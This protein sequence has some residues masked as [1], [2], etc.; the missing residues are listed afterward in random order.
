MAN[1][2]QIRDM[3]FYQRGNRW[4]DSR[5]VNEEKTVEPAKVV[6]FGSAKIH[7]LVERL[8]A[9]ERQGAVVLRADILLQVNGE[10]VRIKGPRE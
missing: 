8:A 1:V 3:A 10:P 7:R 4:V 6:E 9:E 5:L 2:Q